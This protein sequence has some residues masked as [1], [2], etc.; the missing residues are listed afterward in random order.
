M[1]EPRLPS[2]TQDRKL[3]EGVITATAMLYDVLAE[4]GDLEGPI[5]IALAP[6]DY[7]RLE[8]DLHMAMRGDTFPVN[9]SR[10]RET[11]VN[12]VRIVPLGSL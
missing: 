4:R 6:G 8:R 9:F 5:T 1:K 3:I 12:G 2:A 10:P 11:T 7:Y